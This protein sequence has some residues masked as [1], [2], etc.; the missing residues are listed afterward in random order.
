M[1]AARPTIA[2]EVHPDPFVE[3]DPHARMTALRGWLVRRLLEEGYD[4]AA[5]PA[6]AHGVVRVRAA[7]EGF[8][9]EAQA[10]GRPDARRSYAIETGPDAVQRLEVLHH[11]VLGVEQTYEANDVLPGSRLGLA[12]RVGAGAQGDA[13]LEAVAVVTEAAG[14][15]LTAHPIPGDTLACVDPRGHLAEVSVG[16]AEADCGPPVLVLELGDGSPEASRRAARALLEAMRPPPADGTELDVNDLG[17]PPPGEPAPPPLLATAEDPGDP[18][19]MH[20][21]PRA[22]LR[23]MASAGVASRGR[24]LDPLVQA[25]WRMGKLRG[26]GGRLSVSMIPSRG[27]GIQVLDSRLVVGPDWQVP[28]GRRGSFEV[29]ALVGSDLHTYQTDRRTAGD[30]ALAAELPL[31]CG[32]AV[33]R[34]R[35]RVQ[36]GVIPGVS[37]QAWTHEGG[38]YRTRTIRWSRPL[39]RIGIGVGITHGWR[40]E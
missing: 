22:E 25:G 40:I 9:V 32:V 14:V 28:I 21:P 15:T 2:V 27:T 6:Q 26:I 35:T 39:W 13:L 12:V 31:S 7:G 11:A 36:L 4:V 37:S 24:Q 17:G 33:R 30:V 10:Q 8:V 1:L 5:D 16:P 34:G 23:L 29:A 38:P 18:V 20:G 3:T 19:A